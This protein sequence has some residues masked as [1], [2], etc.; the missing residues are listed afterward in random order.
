[1]DPFGS[2]ASPSGTVFDPGLTC[3]TSVKLPVVSLTVLLM[4]VILSSEVVYLV[5]Y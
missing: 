5:L 1:M 4:Y 3:V 2:T